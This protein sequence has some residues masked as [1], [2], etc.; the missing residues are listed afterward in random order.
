MRDSLDADLFGDNN[1]DRDIYMNDISIDM[2]YAQMVYKVSCDIHGVLQ[3]GDAVDRAEKDH[4]IVRSEELHQSIVDKETRLDDVDIRCVEYLWRIFTATLRFYGEP[5]IIALVRDF[6]K[7][8][9]NMELSERWLVG[10]NSG[11]MNR[12]AFYEKYKW[13]L[14]IELKSLLEMRDTTAS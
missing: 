5:W 2:S 3:E 7:D 8:V 14:H 1:P 11:A 10:E 4:L 13:Y 9:A 12:N 6:W